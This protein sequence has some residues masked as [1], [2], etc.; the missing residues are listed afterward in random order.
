MS[1]LAVD[2]SCEVQALL[3]FCL[4]QPTNLMVTINHDCEDVSDMPTCLLHLCYTELEYLLK[5]SSI[6]DA[7]DLYTHLSEKI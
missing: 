1:T 6:I 2:D 4:H 3:A 5:K 7:L